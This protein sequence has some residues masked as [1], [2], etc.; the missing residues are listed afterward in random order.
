[1]SNF[2]FEQMDMTGSSDLDSFLASPTNAEGG[3]Y[4]GHSMLASIDVHTKA[5]FDLRLLH[6]GTSSSLDAGIP[7]QQPARPVTA[8]MRTKV[9]S[10]GQLAPFMRIS[11]DTLVHKSN[12]D[13]W[14]LRKEA[15]GTYFIERLFDDNGSP[16]KG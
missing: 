10:I 12:K 4:L 16:L 9:A 11:A 6:M 7:V 1:M 14:S 15:D 13:L 2:K 8:S 5:D 3:S